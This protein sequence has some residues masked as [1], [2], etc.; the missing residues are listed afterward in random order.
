MGGTPQILALSPSPSAVLLGAIRE[1]PL[2]HFHASWKGE[3]GRMG[4]L[5]DSLPLTLHLVPAQCFGLL[6]VNGA[7]KTSTFKMLTG[8]TE[9]TLGDACLKGHR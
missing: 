2:G 1:A 3:P 4:G 9:V 8:D 7:G 5:G 6:G